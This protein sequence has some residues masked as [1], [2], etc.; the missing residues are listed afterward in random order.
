WPSH[1]RQLWS[2]KKPTTVASRGLLSKS[3]QARQGPAARSP[4]TTTASFTTCSADKF[5]SLEAKQAAEPRS[6]ADSKRSRWSQ[7][8]S[9]NGS[10]RREEADL[11]RTALPPHHLHSPQFCYRGPF[12]G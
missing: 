10:G 11:A 3:D 1:G 12:G 5:I 6:S 4:A 9:K 8:V 7:A 2:K